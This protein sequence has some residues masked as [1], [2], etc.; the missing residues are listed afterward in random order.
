VVAHH[1]AREAGQDPRQDRTP[2]PLHRVPVGRGGGAASACSPRSSVGWR[3][4]GRGGVSVAL[5]NRP[6]PRHTV[7][8]SR[9]WICAHRGVP[10][11]CNPT[12]ERRLELEQI[13]RG[14][15]RASDDQFTNDAPG[16]YCEGLGRSDSSSSS[17]TTIDWPWRSIAS[18]SLRRVARSKATGFGTVVLKSVGA[19]DTCDGPKEPEHRVEPGS[20]VEEHGDPQHDQGAVPFLQPTSNTLI[21]QCW[22]LWSAA[23]RGRGP[24][25]CRGCGQ[26]A[27]P[28]PQGRRQRAGGPALECS[29][30]SG[31]NEAQGDAA[32][33]ARP[34]KPSTANGQ[35]LGILRH[36]FPLR[37]LGHRRGSRLR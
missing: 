31:R 35:S 6:A 8:P 14:H 1:P 37:F 19:A 5:L 26:R 20:G 24:F 34:I 29:G 27:A 15:R 3:G 4:S 11:L 23:R 25:T 30:P 10:I 9:H 28:S 16:G 13:A 32:M 17:S 18:S 22:R 21:E 33:A 36:D 12:L 7:T 2:R